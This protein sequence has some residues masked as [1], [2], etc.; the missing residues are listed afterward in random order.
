MVIIVFH[1]RRPKGK[2]A[3]LRASRKEGAE[4]YFALLNS[5]GL[6]RDSHA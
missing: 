4:P 1:I 3:Y 6:T 2:V 5:G